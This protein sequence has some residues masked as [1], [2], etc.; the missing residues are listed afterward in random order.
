MI[1]HP[2]Q[3]L[4]ALILALFSGFIIR[5]HHTGEINSF[6]NPQYAAF[7]QV[8]SIIFLVLFFIQVTRI[9]LTEEQ[10]VDHQY[11]NILG[12]SHDIEDTKPLKNRIGYVMICLPLVT[13]F[14][15]PYS[16][17]GAAEAMNRAICYSSSET[18]TGHSHETLGTKSDDILKEMIDQPILSLDHSNFSDYTNAIQ[19]SPELFVGKRINMEGFIFSDKAVANGH[20]MLARFIVTHCVADAHVTGVV[21]SSSDK[22]LEK[23][24]G[25]I[26]VRGIIDVH[27]LEGQLVPFIHVQQWNSIDEP[28][29][30]YVYP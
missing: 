15:L 8:A 7:S 28:T 2:Q 20:P 24:K 1:F 29:E 17:L 25:W 22:S 11:C 27:Q 4:K 14:F 13:G 6:I 3:V 12:C 30:P 5:L 18:H 10:A 23:E 9:F 26:S 19:T 16:E 21:L